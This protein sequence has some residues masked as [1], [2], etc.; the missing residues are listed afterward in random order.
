VIEDLMVFHAGTALK[1]G[2]VVNNGGRVLGVTGLGTTVAAAIDKAY[3]GV[4]V[5]C[6]PGVHYRS[7]IGKKALG[8]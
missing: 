4:N 5:I 3:A 7:D 1:D 8:R 2:K 6:W